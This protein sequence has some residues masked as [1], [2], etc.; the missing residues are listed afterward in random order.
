MAHLSFG[1][2]I[3]DDLLSGVAVAGNGKEAKVVFCAFRPLAGDNELAGQ[4]PLLLEELQWPQK[5]HC[6]IGLALSQLS[7]RN[8]TLPFADNKKIEQILPFELDEQLL[9]PVDQQVIA[10]S[11]TMVNKGKEGKE[12]QLMT[13]ALEKETLS[14]YLSLFHAQGLEP[15]CV[16]PTDFVLAE[17]LTGS[18]RETENFLLF[19]CGLSAITITGIHHGAVAFMRHIAYPT[20]VF[21][22]ALFSFDGKEIHTDDAGAAEHAVSRV[23]RALERSVDLFRD[24]FSL[25]LQPDYILLTGPMLLGQGFQEKIEAELGLPVKKSDLIQA[26]IATL[27]ADIAGQWKAEIFDRPLALALQARSR[28]KTAAFNFR[29]N[30]FAPPH[31]LLRSKKQLV[32][33]AVIAGVFFLLSLGYLFVD[34]QQLEQKHDNLSNQMV[35]V[36]KAS[37]PG[38]NPSGDPLLHMRSKLQGMDTVSVSMPIFSEEQRVLF[39]LYDISA[40]IPASL[41][42]HV[43]RLVVDQNAV[44]LRGTTFSY[45]NVNT[46]ETLLKESQRYSEVKIEESS[47]GKDGIRFK[48]KLQLTGVEGENS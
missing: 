24:Q 22:E 12:T 25:N 42:L 46:I 26:D 5:G 29:K 8:I 1:I 38:I 18:D 28:K 47:T 31:Y 11:A 17:R 39:I 19:S 14:Q 41:D 2:D 20:E 32:G 15:N 3:S 16:S 44:T 40:R 35:E 34:A 6:D 10:T 33:A 36:F 4:L 45:S 30:E 9:L 43:T 23:C 27:S 21:T 7:L 13:A 48:I 37:F